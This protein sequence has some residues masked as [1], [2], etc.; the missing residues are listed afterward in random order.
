MSVSHRRDRAACVDIRGG[1]RRTVYERIRD[2]FALEWTAHV[3]RGR[4]DDMTDID[5]CATNTNPTG[6]NDSSLSPQ[7]VNSGRQVGGE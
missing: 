2:A 5:V 1:G 7:V 6:E 4:L 3:E